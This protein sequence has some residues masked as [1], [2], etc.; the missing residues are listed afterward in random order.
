MQE[1]A[2]YVLWPIISAAITA[3][4]GYVGVK[5]KAIFERAEND[6]IKRD[7][8]KTC[9]EAVEQLYKTLH[10]AEK[11]QKCLES[12]TEMLNE[13]GI[14]ATELEIQMLIESA[15]KQLNLAIGKEKTDEG[16][17]DCEDCAIIYGDEV[18]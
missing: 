12:V 2:S 10:G 4:I 5:L 1:F 6:K 14:S 13:R 18:K 7:I 15:V 8:A 17:N 11:Y 9:V 3:L 16:L